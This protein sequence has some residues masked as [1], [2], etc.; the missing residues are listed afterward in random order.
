MSNLIPNENTFLG[1]MVGAVGKKYGSTIVAAPT[2]A[3]ING[4]VDFTDY[5]ITFNA[6]ATGNTVPTPRIK[7]LFE[8]N[9]P[10]TS[11]ATLTGDF[12][13]DDEIDLVWDA[14]PRG[15]R[16]AFVLQRFGGTGAAG[17][18]V[19]AQKTEIWPIQVVSRAGSALQS[20]AAQMF[21]LT[22]SVPH[23]PAESYVVPA[24]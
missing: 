22:G 17:R 1:W 24:A 19:A 4:A 14:L 20:G 21:T 8:T 2:L 23:E 12:Y 11:A 18:P 6:S 16:G 10:G 13:R 3:E 7:S 5:L 15:V 9:I